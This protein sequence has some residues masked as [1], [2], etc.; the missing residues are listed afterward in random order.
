M[1]SNVVAV[2][3]ALLLALAAVSARG[4]EPTRAEHEFLFI[5]LRVHILKAEG[6]P[7]VD[8]AL[9]DVDIRRI[10]RKVNEIWHVAGIQFNLGLILSEP[11]ANLDSYRDARDSAPGGRAP[12]A[13]CRLLVPEANR[14]AQGVDVYFLHRFSVN[15]VYLG[16]NLAF[17]QETARLR[18]VPGGLDEPLPRVL[19][20]ELGHALSLPH[21]QD[22]TNLLASG[23]DGYSLNPGEIGRSRRCAAE[24]PGATTWAALRARAEAAEADGR[25]DLAGPLWSWLA[26]VDGP[27]AAPF[28]LRALAAMP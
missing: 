21:R 26:E 10:V 13:A 1:P 16:R 18:P 23:N 11:A 28:R 22:T 3:P 2:A 12:L 27:S 19:A 25:A 15:G 20:H 8:C 24:V 9:T 4:D 6:L 5:P 14:A 7:E 17:V